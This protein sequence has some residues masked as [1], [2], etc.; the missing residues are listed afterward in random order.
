[1]NDAGKNQKIYR[2]ELTVKGRVQGVGYRQ[3]VQHIAYE[4]GITGEIQNNKDGTVSI[5]AE[6]EKEKLKEFI[7]RININKEETTEEGIRFTKFPIDVKEIIGGETFQEISERMEGFSIKYG[8]MTEELVKGFGTGILYLNMGRE[9]NFHNFVLVIKKY[10]KISIM[11]GIV[12]ALLIAL[13]IL[14]LLN[15][16]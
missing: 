13:V 8:D 3:I 15:I 7:K 12:I 9:D 10:G 6:G 4:L 2:V 11:M 16:L 5:I 14:L 1:L